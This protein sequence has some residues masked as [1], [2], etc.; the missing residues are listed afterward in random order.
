MSGNK[1]PAKKM[2][3]AK[4]LI[5]FLQTKIVEKSLPSLKL[6]PQAS[7]S[8]APK[9]PPLLAVTKCFGISVPPEPAIRPNK[10]DKQ[11]QTMNVAKT[12]NPLITRLQTSSPIVAQ[13]APV[14]SRRIPQ[15]DGER[16]L[17]V[18]KCTT[19]MKVLET[20]DDIKWHYKTKIGREDCSILKS[21]LG[22]QPY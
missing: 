5:A 14:M 8:V 18:I 6:C 10:L 2:R 4:R 17:D 12:P 20:E 15:L 13:S 7:V 21:M 16:D 22:W 3:N 9:A 19:C 11:S 1:S